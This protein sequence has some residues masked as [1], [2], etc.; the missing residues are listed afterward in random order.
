[1]PVLPTVATSTIQLSTEIK[2]KLESMKM[3]PRETFNDVLER[4]LEDV[5]ELDAQTL[6]EV[7]EARAEI[8]AGKYLTQDQ[9]RKAMG[10]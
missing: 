4:L 5:R 9:V 7:E 3:H 6:A 8:R 10:L 2:H 1:M